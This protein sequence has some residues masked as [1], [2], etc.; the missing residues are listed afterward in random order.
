MTVKVIRYPELKFL[1]QNTTTS[2]AL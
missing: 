2:T 1:Q